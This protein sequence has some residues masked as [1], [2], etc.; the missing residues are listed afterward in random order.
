MKLLLA[1]LLWIINCLLWMMVHTYLIHA[2]RPKEVFWWNL[3]HKAMLTLCVG[4]TIWQIG[5]W[6]L[7]LT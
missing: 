5:E 3:Y 7:C 6:I 4:L 1:S 2:G